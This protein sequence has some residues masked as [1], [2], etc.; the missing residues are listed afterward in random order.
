MD[1]FCFYF[2]LNIEA[3]GFHNH[4]FTFSNLV[5]GKEAQIVTSLIH[6]LLLPSSFISF[7]PSPCDD[8]FQI[9]DFVLTSYNHLFIHSLTC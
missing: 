4:V 9:Y 5:E 2:F 6:C 3:L 8:Y 7:I 1:V